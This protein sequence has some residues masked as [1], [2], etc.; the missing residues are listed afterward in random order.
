[1]SLLKEIL[2]TVCEQSRILSDGSLIRERR[3]DR[4]RVWVVFFLTCSISGRSGLPR[5]AGGAGRGA[6]KQHQCYF[7]GGL[8]GLAGDGAVSSQVVQNS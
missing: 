4:L 2:S 3:T 7:A 8:P 1:M 5:K 6:P